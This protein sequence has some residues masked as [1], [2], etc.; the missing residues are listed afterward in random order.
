MFTSASCIEFQV[1]AREILPWLD[2][3]SAKLY[4]GNCSEIHL[5]LNQSHTNKNTFIF[6]TFEVGE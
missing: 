5:G 1:R 4:I 3:L 2:L 6:I